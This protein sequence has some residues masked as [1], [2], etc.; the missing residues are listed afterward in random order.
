MRE[1]KDLLHELEQLR[2]WEEPLTDAEMAALTRSVL[3]RTETKTSAQPAAQRKHRRRVWS[4]ILASGAACVLLLVGLNGINPALAEGLPLLG[5]VFAYINSFTKAPLRSDQLADYAQSVQQQAESS[6]PDSQPQNGQQTLQTLPYTLTLSQVY[7]DS[8]YLRVGLVLTA[9]D[10]SLAGYEVVTLDPPL[11]DENTSRE[12]ANTLYGGITLNGEPVGN[13]L[14][15]CFRKQDDATF[16]CEMDYSL[17]DYTGSTQDMQA[18]LTFSH[19]VGVNT[20]DGAVGSEEKTPLPGSYTLDFTVSADDS[21]TRMGTFSQASQNGF[22]LESVAVTPGETCVTCRADATVPGTVGPA[23]QVFA[24]NG[25]QLQAA[26]GV[27]DTDGDAKVIRDYFD[28]VPE[29][30]ATLTVRVVDK[31]SE[32]LTTLAEWT[33]TL[34]QQ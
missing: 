12:E 22:T 14:L 33:V 3:R 26:N 13:D 2:I 15:P 11:L 24:D 10:D 6:L 18:S 7:C 32:A 30:V 5:N 23:L 31:N 16:V 19:L 28:A 21:L 34:P 27:L 1:S 17:A 4:R 9:E 25:T 20:G 29:G 8:M